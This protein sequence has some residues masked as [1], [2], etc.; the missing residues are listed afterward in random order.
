ML[1]KSV[2]YKGRSCWKGFFLSFFNKKFNNLGNK[3][4]IRNLVVT[5]KML[6]REARVYTGKYQKRFK[7]TVRHLGYKL[8]QFVYTKRLGMGIHVKNVIVKNKSK[9]KT[10]VKKKK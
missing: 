4:N 5:K 10:N 7:L 9:A 6:G 1:I 2:S 3:K 8:G